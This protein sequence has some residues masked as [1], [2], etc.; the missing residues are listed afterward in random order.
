MHPAH[1]TR[2]AREATFDKKRSGM[3]QVLWSICICIYARWELEMLVHLIKSPLVSLGG[4]TNEIEMYLR[5]N[6]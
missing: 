3:I 4:L 5:F 2:F 6:V 1:F